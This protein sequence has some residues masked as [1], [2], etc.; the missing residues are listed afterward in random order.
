M[1]DREA[2]RDHPEKKFRPLA[3]GELKI[4]TAISIGV[5]L[6]LMSLYLGYALG[7]RSFICLI[8]YFVINVIY[9]LKLK[10][11]VMVDAICIALG[12]VLRLLG[13]IYAINELPTGWIT[14]CTLFLSLFL[15]FA[16]RRCELYY[17]LTKDTAPPRPV[18]KEYTIEFL[19]FLLNSASTMTVMCYAI[20]T[21]TSGKNPAL[22]ITVPIVYYAINYFKRLVMVLNIGEDADKIVLKDRTFQFTVIL[23]FLTY[24][25]IMKTNLNLFNP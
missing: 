6:F 24:M 3:T 12:F 4:S 18:L 15:A 8:F 17:F 5:L 11:V 21:T 10:H 22:V 23:W 1:I 13:G 19:D 20:F 16:K 14:L 25:M 2:D 9:T 7:H